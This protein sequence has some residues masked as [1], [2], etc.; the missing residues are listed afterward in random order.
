VTSFLATLTGNILTQQLVQIAGR[1]LLDPVGN[2][3]VDPV[4]LMLTSQGY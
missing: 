4:V 2:P 3:G 1:V